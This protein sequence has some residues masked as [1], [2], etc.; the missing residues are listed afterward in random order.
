M[1]IV[2][3]QPVVQWISTNSSNF[4]ASLR[5]YRQRT[6]GLSEGQINKVLEIVERNQQ[7]TEA[8]P[9]RP[10][11]VVKL[12]DA[13]NTAKRN[14]V[15]F[16]KGP[17]TLR[18]KDFKASLAPAS[19]RNPGAVYIKVDGVY[20][21]KI[22]Q[23]EFFKQ[24]ECTEELLASVVKTMQDPLAAAVEYG[25]ATVR[26]SCCGRSLTNKLSR[27]LG[28]GPICRTSWGL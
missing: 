20:M 7:K 26:C 28:I 22:V 17:P 21:G 8:A 16:A 3:P 11:V 2:I 24:P 6:G 5:S 14:G 27:Q 25:K 10:K 23:G 4:A 12:M 15:K 1:T 13:F 18:F 19:G 9:A